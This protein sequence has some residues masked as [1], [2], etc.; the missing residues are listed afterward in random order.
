MYLL[1][2]TTLICT[3]IFSLFSITH[4]AD[5]AKTSGLFGYHEYKSDKIDTF[6]KW[7]NLRVR[8]KNEQSLRLRKSMSVL[9]P[10][11][12]LSKKFRCI[13]DEW[14]EL[15]TGLKNKS[16]QDKME[17]VNKH[18]NKAR[19]ISDMTNWQ[20]NDYW[21]TLGQFFNKDGDC[22]DYAI[23]K[24]Y[25]LKELGFSTNQMRIV[26]VQDTNLN[27]AHA[28]LAVYFNNKAW[29]LD[30]QVSQIFND[31]QIVHYKPL[32][33]INENSWWLHKS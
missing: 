24:Y 18:L 10:P 19:Y 30:N 2:K 26:I 12:R 31:D 13:S 32:Y 7:Q 28:V 5:I 16:P 3:I 8:Y 29:I 15:I 23:A 27:V 20:Q 21:A 17:A 33:S 25:S 11:C 22:E 14:Q 6:K 4:G 9:K 1:K